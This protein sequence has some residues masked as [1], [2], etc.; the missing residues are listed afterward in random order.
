MAENFGENRK[1]VTPNFS[2]T[3][4]ILNK[5]EEKIRIR[6]HRSGVPP[7]TPLTADEKLKARAHLAHLRRKRG[8]PEE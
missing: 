7:E 8:L 5:M 1:P 6:S 2:A 3:I 4:E